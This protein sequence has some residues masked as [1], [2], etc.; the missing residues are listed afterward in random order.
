MGLEYGGHGPQRGGV[1]PVELN[2]TNMSLPDV[3][4]V[5]A[6]RHPVIPS[7]FEEILETA[8][9][10]LRNADDM[11]L[12]LP[13]WFMCTA[14]WPPIAQRLILSGLCTPVHASSVSTWQGQHLRAGLF[15]VPKPNTEMRRVIVDRRRRNAIERCLRHVVK[16]R[17][18][19]QRWSAEELEHAWRLLTLPHGSQLGELLCSP[20]S[21]V[22][23]WSEDAKDYFY[24]L[25]YPEIR[26]AET[27]I[28]YNVA[29]SEFSP[30]ELAA[31]H[32]PEH[33]TEFALALI[34]PPWGIKSL[35]RWRSYATS[36]CYWSMEDWLWMDGCRI[37][38][39][40][41]LHGGCR[42]LL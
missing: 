5:V 41:R 22:R 35:W 23:C 38:G 10:F 15:G 31:M 24:L 26:H 12:R 40:S 20:Q 19:S 37:D 2:S 36:T 42:L 34:S 1:V 14:S 32:I 11:P 29:S 3:A 17:A 39:L 8:D 18:L 13:S 28:G 25:R 9:I 16:E 33:W 7:E 4:G 21:V 30:E 27:V 6:L